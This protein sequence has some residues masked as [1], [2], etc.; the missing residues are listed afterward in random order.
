MDDTTLSMSARA[1]KASRETADQKVAAYMERHRVPIVAVAALVVAGVIGYTAAQVVSSK[2]NA[3]NLSRID[4]ISKTMTTDWSS[5]DE[6]GQKARRK[7]AMEALTPLVKKSGVSGV[8]ASLLAAEIA[9]QEGEWEDAASYWKSA[10]AKSGKSYTAP[11]AV[12]N[13]AASLEQSGKTAEAAKLY[14][15]ASKSENFMLKSTALFNLGR[16]SEELGEWD[17][18]REAY[19]DLAAMGHDAWANLAKSRLIALDAAGK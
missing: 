19:S 15:E 7:T 9:W 1:G 13:E 3:S 14:G 2:T 6:A 17:K 5:L 10:A 11:L 4:A 12:F 8:R 16:I 18:A